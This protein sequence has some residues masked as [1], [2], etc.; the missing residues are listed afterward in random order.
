VIEQGRESVP[1]LNLTPDRS[2][3]TTAVRPPNTNAFDRP[4]VVVGVDGSNGSERASERTDL[5]AQRTSALLEIHTAYV[6]G[7]PCVSPDESSANSQR[8]LGETTKRAHHFAPA[9]IS[10]EGAHSGEAPA[11]DRIE[12]SKGADLLAFGS[13]C[14]GVFL[15]GDLGSVSQR[16]FRR[17]QSPVVIFRQY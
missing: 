4:R 16:P 2:N 5:Q 12:A 11:A 6:P 3:V 17:A 7:V 10:Q 9:A 14:R 15:G 8:T 13:C 1:N